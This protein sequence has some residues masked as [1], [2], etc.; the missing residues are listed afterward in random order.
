MVGEIYK[1]RLFF[2]TF[3]WFHNY[4]V[5]SSWILGWLV[6]YIINSNEIEFFRNYVI[7]QHSSFQHLFLR[8]PLA[9]LYLRLWK[10]LKKPVRGLCVVMCRDFEDFKSFSVCGLCAVMCWNCEEFQS[11]LVCGLCA[12]VRGTLKIFKVPLWMGSV[13]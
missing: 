3:I 11:F 2:I 13:L 9:L 1:P 5:I 4:E 8:L 6:M 10:L 12:V 7:I